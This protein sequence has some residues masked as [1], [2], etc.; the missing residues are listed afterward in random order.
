MAHGSGLK[1]AR[2]QLTAKSS[3]RNIREQIGGESIFSATTCKRAPVLNNVSPLI[4][5]LLTSLERII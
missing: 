3:E 5:A 4:G 2:R 1:P